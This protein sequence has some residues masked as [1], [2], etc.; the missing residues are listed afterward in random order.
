MS[1]TLASNSDSDNKQMATSSSS[2]GSNNSMQDH[3]MLDARQLQSNN[4]GKNAAI[5][6][7]R[8]N[9]DTSPLLIHH[10][11]EKLDYGIHSW[12]SYSANYHPK[13]I[14]ENKPNDQSSR[15]SS[16]SNNQSQFLM[17]EL[18]HPAIVHTITFG[19]YHKVHVCNLKDFK[20]F[21]GL[22]PD[23][24]TMELLHSGLRNDSESETFS[25]RFKTD[26]VL[27]PCR[28]VKIVPLMAWGAN[29]N[30][31]I[32]YVELRG[33][34]KQELVSQALNEYTQFRENEAIRLCLKHLRQRNL[35]DSFHALQQQT[36]ISMEDD[37]LTKLHQSLV[38]DGDFEVAESILDN[39]AQKSLFDEYINQCSYNPQWRRIHATDAN[40][41]T[42]CMRGGHQLCI[43]CDAGM[44]YLLGG[45][46]GTKDLADFWV[47]DINQDF[48]ICLSQDTKKNG[49]PGPRSCHKI[50]F[51]PQSKNVYVLG[52][53]IDPQSRANSSNE[54]DFYRFDV[55]EQKW[56]LISENTA[57][58]GGP[59]LIYDHQMCC[60]SDNQIMYV[61]G[62]RI[63]SSVPNAAAENTYSGLYSYN[64]ATDVWRLIRSDASQVDGAVHLKSRI[65]HSMLFHPIFKQLYIFAGQRLKDY[66]SDFYVYDIASDKI[67]EMNRDSSKNGGPDAGFTQRATIDYD[68]NEFYVFSGLMREKNS[69]TETVKNTFWVYSIRKDKW[70]KVYQN[71]NTGEDY[72]KQMDEKEPC[73]R[74]A[75]QLVY[76]TKN[77]VQYL[78]GGNPGEVSN[79]SLRLDD[80]WSLKLL[81]PNTSDISRKCKF[82]IRRQ[83][84]KEMCQDRNNSIHALK[85]LQVNIGRLINHEDEKESAEFRDLSTALFG[86]D[87]ESTDFFKMRTELYESLLEYFPESMKQPKG[88]IIDCLPIHSA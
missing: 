54:S 81:K 5:M 41:E 58:Q 52:R 30:F 27:F 83:K 71:E 69:S 75:H 3:P 59:D 64:M 31:S 39:M 74:F 78:F 62:G 40:G 42:P 20:V 26:G 61:F 24:L 35:M 77:K 87:T 53:Y 48:W 16:G 8:L 55:T 19:K 36:K 63:I 43:D 33:I 18:P 66:L 32:W 11:L 2:N 60:D 4:N 57:A 45:W 6:D 15:W 88:N 65:G 34:G 46:D 22:D 13:H 84:F 72:W 76:D 14:Q 82:S 79:M 9:P 1:S 23:N 80:F 12:S 51:D 70:Q 21:G 68:L 17:L 7:R 67:I 49:G 50:C 56:Y 37:V 29:F 10:K 44:V 73:P 28:F 47:Y 85:Y 86:S 25:L 38:L